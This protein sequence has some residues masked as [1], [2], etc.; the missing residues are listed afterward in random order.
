MVT[1]VPEIVQQL[2]STADARRVDYKATR[3]KAFGSPNRI[4][5]QSCLWTLQ[6][7]PDTRTMSSWSSLV[8]STGTFLLALEVLV[9]S[10]LRLRFGHFMSFLRLFHA[11][12]ACD[13]IWDVK[14]SQEVCHFIRRRLQ[15]QMPLTTAMEQLLEACCTN[16]PKRSMG[17]GADN[18]TLIVVLFDQ[19]EPT[20]TPK[21]SCACTL[22]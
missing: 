17:L 11:Q 4:H 21:A 6:G 5:P 9:L 2:E 1:A 22:A 8:Q 3:A 15:R 7:M 18:M 13:G 10:H 12:V 16:D 20:G 19:W 14:T